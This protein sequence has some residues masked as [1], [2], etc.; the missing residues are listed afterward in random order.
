[1]GSAVNGGLAQVADWLICPVCRRQHGGEEPLRLTGR[2]LRC[3]SGHSLDVARQG[4]LT[5]IPAPPGVNADTPEMVASRTRAL[6]A[7]IFDPLD[8][9]IARGL[10]GSRRILEAGAGTGHHLARVLDAVGDAHGLASDIS[11]AAIR[12]AAKAHPRMAAIVADTWQGLPVRSGAVDALMCVFAPRNG[13]EFHRVLAPGGLLSVVTPMPHHLAALRE[14]TG[15][16]GIQPDKREQMIRSLADSFDPCAVETVQHT[17][18]L[19]PELAADVVQM[20]PSAHHTTHLDLT[21]PIE[22]TFAVEVTTFTR[23]EPS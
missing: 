15:M 22:V 6:E 8:R 12:R 19:S 11:V 18:T 20:G 23:R 17:M 16:I 13:G 2:T 4:H 10:A 14:A 7:G 5:M 21:G 3:S 1:M 9:V